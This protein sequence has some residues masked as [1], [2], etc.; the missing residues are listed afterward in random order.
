MSDVGEMVEQKDLTQPVSTLLQIIDRVASDPAADVEKLERMF[1]L[2]ERDQAR[3]AEQAYASA[4]NLAQGHMPSIHKGQRGDQGKYTFANISEV[5]KAAK[6]IWLEY[7]FSLQFGQEECSRDGYLRIGC[8]IK[9]RDGH[10][11]HQWV[12]VPDENKS[13]SGKTIMS[14]HQEIGSG[15]TYGRRYLTCLIFN[16]A[17]D[18][19]IE[20]TL[21]VEDECTAS[22]AM[23]A[24]LESAADEGKAKFKATWEALPTS[25]K[26]TVGHRM[27]NLLKERAK[28]SEE[29]ANVGG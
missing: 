26:N 16:I 5:V 9:Q 1:S 13:Q 25:T 3:V 28:V 24:D 7:G 21:V 18:D 17:T 8:H 14:K 27:F 2:Y 23:I 12:E 6:P 15:F 11:E 20:P 29:E 4:M 22:D 19:D 10:R